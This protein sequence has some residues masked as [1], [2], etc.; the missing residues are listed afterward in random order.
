MNL[1]RLD[2]SDLKVVHNIYKSVGREDVDNIYQKLSPLDS[3]VLGKMLG[4]IISD[5]SK[6][7]DETLLQVMRML[8]FSEEL[9]KLLIE[10]SEREVEAW[11]H[12]KGRLCAGVGSTASMDDLVSKLFCG[13][14]NRENVRRVSEALLNIIIDCMSNPDLYKLVSALFNTSENI[15]KAEEA[16]KEMVKLISRDKNLFEEKMTEYA[17]YYVT[18]NFLLTSSAREIRAWHKMYA[19]MLRDDYQKVYTKFIGN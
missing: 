4:K 18:A 8:V 11:I 5:L 14:I 7:D 12:L 2:E 13:D 16:S 17:F 15:A 19:L 10:G 3:P 1:G 6:K 9:T